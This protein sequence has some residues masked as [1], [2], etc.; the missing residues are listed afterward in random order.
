MSASERR[1]KIRLVDCEGYPEINRELGELAKETV[2]FKSWVDAKF[3]TFEQLL[4]AEADKVKVALD[5]ADKAVAKAETATDKRIEAAQKALDDFIKF[6]HAER[7]RGQQEIAARADELETRV[8]ERSTALQRE[9]DKA[10]GVLNERL[11]SMNEFRRTME[12]YA[13]RLVTREMVDA[14]LAAN[15]KRVRA[16]EDWSNNIQGRL[17]V[18]GGVW[19][20]VVAVLAVLINYTMRKAFE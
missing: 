13:G 2:G 18:F 17:L 16:L 10:E 4:D 15:E 20:L 14:L 7:L 11:K 12:D 3:V 1:Q 6:W 19:G 5:A 9:L 8:V